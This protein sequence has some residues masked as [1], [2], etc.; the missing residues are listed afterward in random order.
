MAVTAYLE[1]ARVLRMDKAREFALRTL[2]RLLNEAWD[3]DATLNHVIAYPDGA[4]AQRESAGHS[5]RLCIHCERLHRC[6]VCQRQDELLPRG[7]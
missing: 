6:L 2:D 1:T 5:G 4:R 7:A 3:G